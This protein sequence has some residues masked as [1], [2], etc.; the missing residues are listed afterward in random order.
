[1]E[2]VSSTT[3]QEKSGMLFYRD[4]GESHF[5]IAPRMLAFLKALKMI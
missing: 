1:M 4:V 5:S 2:C 3:K